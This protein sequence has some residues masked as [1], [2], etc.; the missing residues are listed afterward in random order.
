MPSWL[1]KLLHILGVICAYAAGV[2]LILAGVLEWSTQPP[3]QLVTWGITIL[4]TA[5]VA[6]V[7]GARAMP[8]IGMWDIG[9]SFEGLNDLAVIIIIVILAAGFGISMAF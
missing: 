2:I 7:D 9:A 3:G 4:L 5:T 1:K 6:V 8:N